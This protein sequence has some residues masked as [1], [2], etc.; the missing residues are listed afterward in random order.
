MECPR[1]YSVLKIAKAEHFSHEIIQ[2]AKKT[3]VEKQTIKELKKIQ[4]K[5]KIT[6][7]MI[8]LVITIFTV[9]H[10]K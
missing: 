7:F 4:K 1:T 6:G 2:L 3:K 5:K 10:G 8:L 9:V